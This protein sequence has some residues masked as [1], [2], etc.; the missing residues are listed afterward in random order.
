[1]PLDAV[2]DV[3]D[4]PAARELALHRLADHLLVAAGDDR[5]HGA[6]VDRRRRDEREVAQARDG[7]LQRARD[8][9]R[10]EREHVDLRAELLDALLVRDAEALLLV[11]DEEA[12]VLEVHVLRE[13]AVR[14]DDDVDLARP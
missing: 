4:L 2:V 7:H 1:M 10:R 6:A 3:E 8:G 14:A 13:E 12:E 11:D 9:R 5:A